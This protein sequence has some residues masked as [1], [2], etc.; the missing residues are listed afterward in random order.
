MPEGLGQP[1]LV[2]LG[3]DLDDPEL[4]QVGI[5]ELN[6]EEFEVTSRKSPNR[7]DQTDLRGVGSTSIRTTELRFSHERRTNVYAIDSTQNLITS[8]RLD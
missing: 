4:F 7:F 5:G 1:A 6:I 3:T 2:L 8:P